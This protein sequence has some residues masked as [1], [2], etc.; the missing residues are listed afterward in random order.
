MDILILGG[1]GQLG[2]TVY[3][4]LK[5]NFQTISFNKSQLSIINKK[6]LRN[7]INKY[8]PKFIINCSAYTKVELAET[9]K[10]KAD[11]VN[12]IGIKNV[13]EIAQSND[14]GL[15]HF[16][17]DYVFDGKKNSSYIEVDK[18]VPI[19]EYGASKLRGENHIL[20]NYDKFFI[21]RVSGIF[22]EHGDNF[23]K[24]MMRLKDRNELSVVSDQL[25]KP[26]SASFIANFLSINL[27]KNNFTMSNVGLYHLTCSGLGISWFDFAKLIFQEMT[28][29]KLIT[30]GPK[31][32]PILSKN[33]ESS[34][35][36]PKFSVLSNDKVKE[37]FIL[38]HG[39]YR[40]NL[41]D[42]LNRIYQSL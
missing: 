22:S 31:I 36:R 7:A 28:E 17:T 6:E 15:I 27:L 39:N 41:E 4:E 21:F 19:N 2:Q 25:M 40:Q 12:Y 32:S 33:Y 5:E 26:S 13:C 8:S 20:K 42:E 11:A 14:I 1:S 29:Q 3:R 37:K 24:T 10:D 30:Q 38:P 9:E 34:V 18:A 35:I 23:V 16:S